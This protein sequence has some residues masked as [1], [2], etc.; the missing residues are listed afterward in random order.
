[1]HG[2][3]GEKGILLLVD[4]QDVGI[5]LTKQLQGAVEQGVAKTDL[6]EH[7]Q[8]RESHAPHRGDEPAALVKEQPE[9]KPDRPGE[10]AHQKSSAGSARRSRREETRAERLHITRLTNNMPPTRPGVMKMGR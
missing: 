7:E 6:Q 5:D 10:L 8:Q 2:V 1:M 4:D 3:A 9:G